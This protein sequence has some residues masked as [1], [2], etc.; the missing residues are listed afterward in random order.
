MMDFHSNPLSELLAA[1]H[2]QNDILGVAR[3]KYLLKE[4]AR[5]HFEAEMISGCPEAS[6]AARVTTCQAQPEW[7][8]FHV[9]LARLE[10]IYEFQKLKFTIM[11]KEWQTQY[12]M[13]KLDG[14]LIKK[15]Q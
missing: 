4:A 13:H 5:K 10:S 9:E 6:Q 7:L 1:L 11:E 12:L 2:R 8:E 3:N 15:E 14:P